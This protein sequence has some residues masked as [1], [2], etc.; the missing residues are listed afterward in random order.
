M[1]LA[2]QWKS[3][4]FRGT[5]LGSAHLVC[6]AERGSVKGASAFKSRARSWGLQAEGPSK[7]LILKRPHQPQ[8]ITE[9]TLTVDSP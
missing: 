9:D 5:L 2:H 3:S 4:Q 7:D 6:E 8:D 1:G